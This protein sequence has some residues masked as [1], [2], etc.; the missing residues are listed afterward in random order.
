MHLSSYSG[1]SR[2][3]TPDALRVEARAYYAEVDLDRLVAAAASI[4]DALAACD[5]IEPRQG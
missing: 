5:R 3:R 1:D 2:R 4:A